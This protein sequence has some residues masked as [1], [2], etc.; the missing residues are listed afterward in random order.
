M[1]KVSLCALQPVRKLKGNKG[2]SPTDVTMLS[3]PKPKSHD[4]LLNENCSFKSVSANANA[5]LICSLVQAGPAGL[6]VH[7]VDLS[8]FVYQQC[9]NICVPVANSWKHILGHS[10]G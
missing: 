10:F 2:K 4:L 5:Y 6:C 7:S 9:Y 8:T 1:H 3:W